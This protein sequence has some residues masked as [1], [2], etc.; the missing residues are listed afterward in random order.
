MDTQNYIIEFMSVEW[1]RNTLISISLIL[2]IL[3]LSNNFFNKDQKLKI[4]K[5]LSLFMIIMTITDHSRNIMNGLWNVSENLPFH[6]CGLTNLIACSV[7][8]TKLNKR[9]FEFFYFAGIIGGIQAFLTPQINNFDGS[10]FEYISYHTS[11]A[12]IILIPIFLLMNLNYSITKF[13][14]FRV[15][16]YLNIIIAFIIPLNFQIESNYMYLASPPNVDNPLLIGDWPYYI[17]FWEIIVILF[18]YTLYV[19]STKKFI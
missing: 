8:F 17:F 18:T 10:T 9:V 4:V 14:W 1:I 2:I 16:V 3:F 13:S 5:I 15:W 6:M 11:H 19:V 7:I 12:G